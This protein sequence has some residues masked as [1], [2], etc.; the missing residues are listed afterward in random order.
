MVNIFR[1]LSLL[2]IT[3]DKSRLL[4]VFHRELSIILSHVSVTSNDR[5]VVIVKWSEPKRKTRSIKLHSHLRT[6]HSYL[7]RGLSLP[8]V[9]RPDH[10][11]MWLE[12]S[13]QI[14]G[15][16]IRAKP[17][18]TGINFGYS[19]L[20]MPNEGEII[21]SVT[22]VADC[23]L[24][25]EKNSKTVSFTMKRRWRPSGVVPS[26]TQIVYV[27]CQATVNSTCIRRRQTI[28]QCDIPTSHHNVLWH[29]DITPE[30]VPSG[31]CT[32]WSY[33][34]TLINLNIMFF[35]LKTLTFDLW[36]G[37]SYSSE[38]FSMSTLILNFRSVCQMI[39]P[40]EH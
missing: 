39:Q 2:D 24:T 13:I 8:H 4:K 17:A 15:I 36:P 16:S 25:I 3:S 27:E 5:W 33:Y 19:H 18:Q 14:E 11:H 31:I 30:H 21:I 22:E 34:I 7:S 28:T 10:Q 6:G 32:T 38:I 37:P 23:S 26:R 1:K 20:S 35:E 12:T 29:P 9:W 40:L